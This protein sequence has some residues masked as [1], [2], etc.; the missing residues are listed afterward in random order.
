MSQ[1]QIRSVLRSVERALNTAIPGTGPRVR[2]VVLPGRGIHRR[3][4]NARAREV[5][6]AIRKQRGATSAELQAFL[7]VNRNVVAGAVHRL[8]Q[9]RAIKSEIVTA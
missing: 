5:L 4:L 9:A 7:K 8:R 3:K 6:K 2:Y 1:R